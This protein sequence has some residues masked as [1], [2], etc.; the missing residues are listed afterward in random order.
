MRSCWRSHRK[1]VWRLL[2][3][4]LGEFMGQRNAIDG[5]IVE[6]VAELNA[7]S[8]IG[9]TG[10]RSMAALVL[11]KP[12]A[13]RCQ[14]RHVAA[15]SRRLEEF[16]QVRGRAARRR[17]SLDQVG[18]LAKRA[19]PQDLTSTGVSLAEVATVSQLRTAVKLEPRP[20]P[21]P[22]PEPVTRSDH[23]TMATSTRYMAGDQPPLLDARP[24]STPP[25]SRT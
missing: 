10:A 17:L 24:H 13:H 23:Q 21:D 22:Q 8:V 1:S 3:E 7:T 16:P 11:R 20:D 2:F 5:R 25:C 4:E 6:I 9:M 18:V 19:R 15:L 12:A 14:R